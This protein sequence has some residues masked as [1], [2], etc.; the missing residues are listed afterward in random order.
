MN[1]YNN[2]KEIIKKTGGWGLLIMAAFYIIPDVYSSFRENNLKEDTFAGESWEGYA[3]HLEVE[4]Q[5]EK[6][7]CSEIQI[8]NFVLT[9]ELKRLR[10]LDQNSQNP[11]WEIDMNGRVKYY[12]PAF[13]DQV[14]TTVGY[15]SE[16]IGKTWTEVFPDQTTSLSYME[17]DRKV[18]STGVSQTFVEYMVDK[19]G[20]R[21]Q[22]V[23]MK[24]P[25]VVDG[26]TMGMRGI[27][28]R[29]PKPC[30]L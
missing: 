5:R 3:K 7:R 10:A 29:N 6:A 24:Q 12:N 1:F 13:R 23:T 17:S 27:A 9:A 8:E 18:L 30:N 11:I 21:S 20:Q 2:Y 16:A 15:E 14:L 25:I 19:I 4:F 28:I 26:R 22:W